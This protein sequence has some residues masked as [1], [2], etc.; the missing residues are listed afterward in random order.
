[1][2]SVHTLFAFSLPLL[3]AYLLIFIRLVERSRL[4]RRDRPTLLTALDI[5]DS[6]LMALAID[7]AVLTQT[8]EDAELSTVP[9]ITLA[10]VA[11]L[12][13]FHASFFLIAW[14][15]F[16]D[17]DAPQ[18]SAERRVSP[19]SQLFRI[20][21]ALTLL[22]TNAVTMLRVIEMWGRGR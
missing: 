9:T 16:S 6:A 10:L 7:L 11:V 15:Q 13:V 19:F 22:T 3:L 1:M 5:R 21:V 2:S 14:F 20:Y 4:A 12:F 18:E 8:F 17:G